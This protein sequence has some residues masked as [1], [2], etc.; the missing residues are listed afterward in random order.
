VGFLPCSTELDPRRFHTW[1]TEWSPASLGLESVDGH[2]AGNRGG[3]DLDETFKATDSEWDVL[4]FDPPNGSS[5]LAS[6]EF[7]RD[8]MGK[9]S[10]LF[11]QAAVLSPHLRRTLPRRRGSSGRKRL[12]RVAL[13]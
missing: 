13:F 9:L 4:Y 1:L 11:N 7:Y 8:G 10:A 3:S 12:A 6:G 5:E 2:S